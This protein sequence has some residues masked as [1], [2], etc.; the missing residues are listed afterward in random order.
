MGSLQSSSSLDVCFINHPDRT[1]FAGDKLICTCLL[2][3]DKDLKIDKISFTLTGKLRYLMEGNF[4]ASAV[5]LHKI[6][7]V[8]YKKRKFYQH[9]EFFCANELVYFRDD[10]S[11][12]RK[13]SSPIASFDLPLELPST[14]DNHEPPVIQYI[15]VVRISTSNEIW[16]DYVRHFPFKVIARWPLT[17]TSRSNSNF[18]PSDVA[19]SLSRS[20]V[21]LNQNDASAVKLSIFVLDIL[22]VECLIPKLTYHIGESITAKFTIHY[23]DT[24]DDNRYDYL[25]KINYQ[26]LFYENIDR[27]KR[28]TL[29]KNQNIF[30]RN[31]N[32][33]DKSKYFW[34]NLFTPNSSTKPT[35][36]Y[37]LRIRESQK[38]RD[39]M[40]LNQNIHINARHV[41]CLH[42]YFSNRY[43][44]I[45]Q[46]IK[47]K[48]LFEILNTN[49]YMEADKL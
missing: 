7:I 49:V 39:K 13:W 18:T 20:L 1:Y 19:S 44:S 16:S 5:I 17:D 34:Y 23:H 33:D 29:L 2:Q 35:H 41:L 30:E 38:G 6:P 15:L 22:R 32:M 14:S 3:T 48:I 42:F 9:S 24:D 46:D 8:G 26:I 36:D 10:N 12:V 21:G 45:K 28:K 47:R 27:F 31:T 25:S 43:G 4:N 11:K 37:V 40:A